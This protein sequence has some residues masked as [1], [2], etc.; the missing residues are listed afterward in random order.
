[1]TDGI[2][3]GVVPFDRLT[4][5]QPL[6]QSGDQGGRAEAFRTLRTNLQFTNVDDPPRV[7]V[8]TSALPDEGKSTTSANIALTLALSGASVALV[9]ADLRKPAMSKYLGVSSGAGL[10]NVLAGQYDLREVLVPYG[11]ENLALLPSGPKP[12]NP[13]EL[14]GSAH[15]SSLLETLSTHF[16]YVIIDAPPLL[17]V[18]DAAIVA[19]MA[20]GALVVV[21]HGKTT[22][23]GLDRAVQ[24]LKA[25]NAKLLGTVL[26]FAPRKKRGGGYD[27][28]GYGYGYGT[29]VDP[30]QF[31]QSTMKP[32]AGGLAAIRQSGPAPKN[33]YPSPVDATSQFRVDGGDPNGAHQPSHGQETR[34]GA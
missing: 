4:A 26:N 32:A 27:G 1:M 10:T 12:P 15:M 33:G 20:D 11:Q 21:R 7:I 18:T 3:L 14:L 30:N 34:R 24:S 31:R 2:P 8:V 9:E 6:V 28:Y 19:A 23:E 25:V 5:Q 29:P 17:P 13:S 22:R 16:D